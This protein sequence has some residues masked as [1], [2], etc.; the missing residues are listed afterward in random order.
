M[1]NVAARLTQCFLAVFPGLD[2]AQ[3]SSAGV[4]TVKKWDSVAHVTLLSV[5][6][7][8]FGLDLD[9]EKF[10]GATS[11]QTIL[12]RLQPPQV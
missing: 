9:F 1:D 3:V 7:E 5:I 4:D 2:P 8:E 12:D 6:G 11:F 10:E